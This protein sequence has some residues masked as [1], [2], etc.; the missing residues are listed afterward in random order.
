MHRVLSTALLT[1]AFVI[2]F[3]AL[4]QSK[5]SPMPDMPGMNM[6]PASQTGMDMSN[7][8]TTLIETELANLTSGTSIEP[9]STPAAMLMSQYRGWTLML[10]GTAFIADTRR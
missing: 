2:P 6:R 7:P 5:Q 4:A 3:Q 8:P 10:H 9:A 1:A